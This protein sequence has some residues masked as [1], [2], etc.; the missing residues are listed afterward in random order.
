M[1]IEKINNLD[2]DM[3]MKVLSSTQL[4]AYEK[5]AFVQKN[6]PKINQIMEI[7]ISNADYKTLMQKRGLKKFRPLK[8]SFTKKGDKILLAKALKINPSEVVDYIKG[9]LY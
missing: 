7:K 6:Q 4:S 3:L 1:K 2:F 8:N 9:K 5:T